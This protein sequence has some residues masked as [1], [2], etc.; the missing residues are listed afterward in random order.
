MC[1][2]VLAGSF[3]LSVMKR[4][5]TISASTSRGGDGVPVA[6]SSSGDETLAVVCWLSVCSGAGD[7]TS[8][9]TVSAG[10]E[11]AS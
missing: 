6:C 11:P 8:S 2:F 5:E 9:S 4:D 1:P 7:S 10:R 3:H